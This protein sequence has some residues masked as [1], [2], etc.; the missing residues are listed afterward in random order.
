MDADSGSEKPN[1]STKAGT[2]GFKYVGSVRKKSERE[3]L[4][5]VECKPCKKFYDVV[6]P[7]A[8]NNSN[9]DKQNICSEHHNGVS[10]HRYR[11]FLE[12]WL[13]ISNASPSRVEE[14]KTKKILVRDV[15]TDDTFDV[16]LWSMWDLIPMMI[17]LIPLENVRENLGKVMKEDQTN[18]PKPV[19]INLRLD[20]SD[21]ETQDM[22]VDGGL[23]KLNTSTKAGTSGFLS[24]L[25]QY[26]RNLR[27]SLKGV[28]C[29]QCKKFY[30][31]VLPSAGN[32]S[33]NDNPNICSEHH[34]GVSRHRYR[35]LIEL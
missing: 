18:S 11:V 20:N 13:S 14:L 27:E 4:K 12:L 7:G 6:L 24:M 9:N 23:E 10:R 3:S 17:S 15:E 2:S 30:D 34:N 28:E 31:V 33:N 5:G 1:T 26:E 16:L 8:G 22:D 21:D 19:P 35:V 29:K 32:N 25:K